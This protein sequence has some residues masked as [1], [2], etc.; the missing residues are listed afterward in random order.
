MQ[1]GPCDTL[2]RLGDVTK[3]DAS[4]LPKIDLLIGGFT[5]SGI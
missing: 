3:I 4:K 1:I 5:L 2:N